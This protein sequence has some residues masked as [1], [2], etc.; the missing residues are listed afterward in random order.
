MKRVVSCVALLC[1]F[2]I[3]SSCEQVNKTLETVDKAKGMKEDIEKKAQAVTQDLG[4]K[5]EDLKKTGQETAQQT[6]DKLLG[7]DKKGVKES[8]KNDSKQKGG[9]DKKEK[10]EKEG[11]R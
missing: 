4:K 9:E 5:A 6:V 11:K 10:D 3:F 8:D 7:T 1:I 2:L